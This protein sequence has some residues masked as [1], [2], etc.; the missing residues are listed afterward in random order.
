MAQRHTAEHSCRM[1][2][3]NQLRPCPYHQQDN[4][5]DKNVYFYY[6]RKLLLKHSS[7]VLLDFTLLQP[8]HGMTVR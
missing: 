3:M 4:A 5:K 2:K 1:C 7:I 6:L 8:S